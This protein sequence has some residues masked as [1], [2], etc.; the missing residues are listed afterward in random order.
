MLDTP[1]APEATSD[2]AGAIHI[3]PTH[4]KPEPVFVVNP[5]AAPVD[6]AEFVNVSQSVIAEML[7]R[8]VMEDGMTG[9]AA[10]LLEQVFQIREAAV[11]RLLQR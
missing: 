3:T 11:D 10:W 7:D 2:D 5:K 6:V 1:A 4:T 9:K 8:A